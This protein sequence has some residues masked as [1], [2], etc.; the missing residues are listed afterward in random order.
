MPRLGARSVRSEAISAL[1]REELECAICF[2]LLVDAQTTACGHAFCRKCLDELALYSQQCP[3]C[4]GSTRR[5][6][7]LPCAELGRASEAIAAAESEAALEAWRERVEERATW[8]NARQLAPPELGQRIDV[9]DNES[10]WCSAFVREIHSNPDHART[11]LVHY[12]GWDALYDEFI[13]ES[14]PRL[15]PGGFYTSREGVPKYALNPSERD[16]ARMS[17]LVIRRPLVTLLLRNMDILDMISPL[18][19]RRAPGRPPSTDN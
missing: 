17:Y 12:D 19:F 3:L 13:C 7:N 14:S 5:Q 16:D 9:M 2:E 11:L 15:A 4:R 6:A 18:R 10:V 1:R 8:H